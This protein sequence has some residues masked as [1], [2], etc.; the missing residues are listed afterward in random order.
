[1][2]KS[3][4]QLTTNELVKKALKDK[5]KWKPRKGYVY[6]AMIKQGEMF[7]LDNGTKG[8]LIES[9]D[10]ASTVVVTECPFANKEEDRS[11]YLGLNRWSSKTE[12]KKYV[13]AN[14]I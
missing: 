2:K 14:Q 1:M 9:N 4:K 7:I 8:I 10:S 11:Y 3:V 5:P 13:N 12:V 6:L